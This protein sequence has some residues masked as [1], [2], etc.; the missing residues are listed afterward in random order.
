MITNTVVD[1]N[2]DR[3][4]LSAILQ[5]STSITDADVLNELVEWFGYGEE[6]TMAVFKACTSDAGDDR[7]EIG[8]FELDEDRTEWDPVKGTGTVVLV[9]EWSS[10]YG[11]ADM[12]GY[13]EVEAEIDVALDATTRTITFTSTTTPVQPPPDDE[14]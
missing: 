12:D 11:C 5:S 10:H 2:A 6:G 1:Q 13:G 3:V 7:A 8:D 4:I 9:A 14:F